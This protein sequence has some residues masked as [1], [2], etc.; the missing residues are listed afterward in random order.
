VHFT[1]PNNSNTSAIKPYYVA[2]F[3]I[4]FDVLEKKKKKEAYF[5]FLTL[6]RNTVS[7]IVKF[8]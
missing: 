7:A 1:V 5:N 2:A 8:I 4:T 6:K 3:I